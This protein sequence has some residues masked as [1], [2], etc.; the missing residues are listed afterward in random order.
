MSEP[1]SPQSPTTGVINRRKLVHVNTY[2]KGLAAVV[3]LFIVPL[4]VV[5]RDSLEGAEGDWMISLQQSVTSEHTKRFFKAVS[6]LGDRWVFLGLSCFL[7]HCVNPAQG[8]KIIIVASFGMYCQGVLGLIYYEPRPSWVR[9]HIH[10]YTCLEG[11]GLPSPHLTLSSVLFVY[12]LIQYIHRTNSLTRGLVYTLTISVLVL[13]GF[14]RIYLGDNYLH[15]VVITLCYVFIYL[16]AALALD[17]SVT[18]LVMQCAF[19]YHRNKQNTIYWYLATLILLLFAISVY[20]IIT[21]NRTLIIKYIKNANNDCTVANDLGETETFQQT[22]YIFYACGVVNGCMFITRYRS[23]KWWKTPVWKRAVRALLMLAFSV[24]LY[25]MLEAIP[26]ER[27][28]CSY[29]FRY[30][31]F[32]F[33]CAYLGTAGLSILGFRVPIF[34]EDSAEQSSDNMSSHQLV[35]IRS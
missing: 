22:A 32:N 18:K 4:E 29:V 20:D 31:I 10:S 27:G 13:M 12:L 7:V 6:L 3:L 26:M 15:Q 23:A 21:L 16:T 35:E 1:Q 33:L 8:L 2:V 17:L 14:T 19:G 30:A 25:F 34:R 11:F 9:P 28:T 24:G 5:L